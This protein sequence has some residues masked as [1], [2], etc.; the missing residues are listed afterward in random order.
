MYGAA[1]L[2]GTFHGRER[3]LFVMSSR[4]APT[5]NAS[6]S[7]MDGA[8]HSS[9]IFFILDFNRFGVAKWVARLAA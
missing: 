7:V 3:Q 6:P 1:S 8:N 5:P 4:M 9:I 2:R